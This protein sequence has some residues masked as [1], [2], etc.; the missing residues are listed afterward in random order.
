MKKIAQG[1]NALIQ[2]RDDSPTDNPYWVYISFGTYDEET[3]LDSFGNADEDVFFYS[4][5]AELQ[6]NAYSEFI[7][8]ESQ[9]EYEAIYYAA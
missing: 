8:L 3:E 4:D 7:V 9:L 1:A 6:A 2:Y 5:A